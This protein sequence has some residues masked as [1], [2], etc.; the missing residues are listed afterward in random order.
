MGDRARTVRLPG[1]DWA[2]WE[3]AVLRSTGFPADGLGLFAAPEC[4]SAADA[5]LAGRGSEDEFARALDRALADASRAAREIAADPLFR[6]ALTWQNPAAARLLARLAEPEPGGG[7]T[8]KELRRARHKRRARES[9][10]VRYWQRYC[11]KN[12]TIG[13]FGPVTWTRI[14]PETAP[15]VV[16]RPGAGLV[17]SRRI[18]YEFWALEAYVE[19]LLADPVVAPWLPAGIHPHL[20]VRDGHVLQ[21][22]KEPAPLDEAEAEVLARCD[23]VRPV[24]EIAPDPRSLAALDRLVDDGIVWRGVNMPYNA[25]AESVLR[26]HLAA[27]PDPDARDRARAGLDRLD[28]ARDT[29][30]AAAGDPDA[31]AEALDG[32]DAE[33]TAVT[34]VEPR[35]RDGQ[36]YAGRRVCFEDTVRDL[37]IEFGRPVLD[38]LAGPFGHVLLPAARW[39]SA[40]LADAYDAAFRDLYARLR[41]P[42]ADGVPMPRFWDAVQPLLTGPDRPA[43][44]VAAEFARRWND[45]IGL[46]PTSGDTTGDTGGRRLHL[47]SE[48]LRERAAQLF[49]TDRP[50]WAAARIHSPDLHICASSVAALEAG[51]FTL[52]LGEMHNAWPTLDSA[53]FTDRHPDPDSLREAAADDI[54]RQ[55][56]PLY[57]T[58]WPQYTARIAPVL[59]D[60]DHQLAFTAAPGADPER[61]LP[62]VTLTVTDRGGTLE[63]TGPGGLRRPLRE[64][65]ALLFGWLG[66]EAFKRLGA[67]AHHPRV[68][69]DRLVV[70]RETWRT[71]VEGTGIAPKTG[72]VPE[73][74]AARRLRASLGLP[75]RVFAKVGTEV[76]P[77]Y[78]DFTGPRYVSS[79]A[80]M[81]RAARDSSGGDV[82]VTFTELL[83]GPED[84]WLEDGRGRRYFSELRMQIRDPR[85]P[86]QAT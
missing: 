44:A 18:A 47:R 26:E 16:A 28:R 70:V 61:V 64:V 86:R 34:G 68:T 58:W 74:I 37:D 8:G 72:A 3:D 46:A 83:P 82:L 1:T 38:A 51:E 66:A 5:F 22:G 2:V 69:L 32:L 79:F 78:V 67:G 45:L 63:A 53:V 19:A 56:R 48:D 77:V 36:M 81:V 24:A 60:T 41:E 71:T 57:P 33:F 39:V 14:V 59:G 62:T 9:A 49:H 6:E 73:Y 27:I 84:A 76:K 43:D 54:G 42:G 13:F 50:G 30:G 15:A 21:P 25:R 35:R 17:R 40:A 75:E 10:V 52:V 85:R 7:M 80:A 12:D 65:F 20:A 31:L 11:G 55:F 23:G 4:A 29:V